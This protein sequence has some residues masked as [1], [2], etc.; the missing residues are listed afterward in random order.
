MSGFS[1]EAEA[2]AEAMGLD[3]AGWATVA[4]RAIDAG[5][6]PPPDPHEDIARELARAVWPAALWA[7]NSVRLHADFLAAVRRMDLRRGDEGVQP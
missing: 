4:Q 2:L 5:W 6:Q 7:P 1:R 3:A